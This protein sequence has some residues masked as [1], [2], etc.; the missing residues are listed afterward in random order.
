[1]TTPFRKGYIT[2]VS[3]RNGI[4]KSTLLKQ[5]ATYL[6][7]QGQSVSFLGHDHS[8][9]P[10]QTVRS[11]LTF[12][13]SILS[14]DITPW[15]DLLEDISF[16]KYIF[17]LSSGQ[18]QR[19]SIACHLDFSKDAWLLDEPFDTLDTEGAS[20]LQNAFIRY[21]AQDKILVLVDHTFDM[22]IL[23]HKYAQNRPL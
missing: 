18:Q 23:L 9:L 1:M 10:T 13:Q 21:I 15:M 19:V 20:M 14:H 7:H 8:L 2:H 11:Q 22:R 6:N 3:G 17:E 5:T 4:G 16:D 12:Y